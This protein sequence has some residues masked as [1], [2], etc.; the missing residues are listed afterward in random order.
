MVLARMALT[1]YR[2]FASRQLLDFRPI[3]VVLGRNN[4]GKSAL[5]RAPVILGA[6]IRTDSPD[7]INIDD[8]SEELLESF[9]D[10]IHGGPTGDSR[11]GIEV[12]VQAGGWSA[13]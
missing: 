11:I 7:P 1:N 6:G 9:A 13:S 3:T 10:L 2:G 5:V 12:G 4:A 8:I